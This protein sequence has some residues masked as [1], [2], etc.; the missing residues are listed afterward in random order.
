MCLPSGCYFFEIFDEYGDGICCGYGQGSYRLKD[1]NGNTILSGGEF[2]FSEV[3]EFCVDETGGE[4]EEGSDN[5][6]LFDF[7]EY[8]VISYGGPQDQG[9]HEVQNNGN[10]LAIGFNAWKAIELSYQVTPQ[11]VLEFDFASTN[12]GEIHGIGLDDNTT[13]SSSKTFKVHGTQNWGNGDFDD[14][15]NNQDWKTYRIPVGKYYTGR[16][17]YLF[18][19]ADEDSGDR[20]GNSYFRNVKIYEGTSCGESGPTS[21]L[22]ANLPKVIEG[23]QIG[24]QSLQVYPNPTSDLLNLEYNSKSDANHTVR[25]YNTMGQLMKSFNLLFYQGF[26]QNTIDVADLSAGTYFLEIESNGLKKSK[27]FSVV[28]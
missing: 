17:N 4:G 10:I 21:Y 27:R 20:E 19:V 9:I 2:G 5:C 23:T 26:N 18:F 8:N 3:K 16:Y 1:A 7:T 24:D 12:Q 11:T 28:R 14:Y 15:P 6:V 22:G 13:I 25:V